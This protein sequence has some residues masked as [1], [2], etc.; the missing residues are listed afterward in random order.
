MKEH[1]IATYFPIVQTE[2]KTVDFYQL[3]FGQKKACVKKPV[4][5]GVFNKVSKWFE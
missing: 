4:S 2:T 1:V 3:P 5:M